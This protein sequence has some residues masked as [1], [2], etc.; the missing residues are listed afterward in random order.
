MDTQIKKTIF[1]GIQPTGNFTLGNYLGAVLN[2]KK[3]QTDYTCL[4]S[5]VDMHSI[6]VRQDPIF[7]RKQILSSYALLLACGIDTKKSLLFIQSHVKTHSELSWILSCNTQFGELSRMTQFKDKAK[8]HHNDINIGLFT[9][10]VLMASDILLYGTDLVPVGADQKQHLELARDIAKRFNN[11]YG[12]VFKVPEPYIP[13]TGSK[14]MSLQDP[15]KK[16]SKSDENPNAIISILDDKDT[17]IRKFKK[18]VTDSHNIISFSEYQPGISNLLTIYSSITDISIEDCLL[19]FQNFNYGDFK[20]AVGE[21]VADSLKDI[22]ENYANI[23]KEK[24]YLEQ[25]YTENAQKATYLSTK[26]I[27]KVNKKIGLI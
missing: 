20:L 12:D 19:Y 14:I 15:T 17:I 8:K 21:T 3:L 25:T 27:R 16:M 6:T 9:Y 24:D 2:W 26:I 1:S 18:S 7:L 11:I 22:R 10:P 23:I 13:K 4:F 5:V